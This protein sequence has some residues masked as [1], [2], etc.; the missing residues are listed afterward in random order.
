MKIVTANGKK[1]LK[2]TRQEW[3]AI[4]LK[5]EEAKKKKKKQK[6]WDES[7]P[8]AICTESIGKTEGTKKRS[9]WSAD[10]EK[11]Y[12]RCKKHVTKQHK[13]K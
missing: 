4:G 1:F 13:E 3:E 5:F 11:R 10:A 2:M 12:K 8:Y 9:K 6:K 7:T